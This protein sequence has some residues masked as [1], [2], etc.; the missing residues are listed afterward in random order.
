MA[1]ASHLAPLPALL[2]DGPF[3]DPFT[4]AQWDILLALMDTIIPSIQRGPT[5]VQ[6]AT[7][8]VVADAEY[9][10]SIRVVKKVVAGNPDDEA[11]DKYFNEKASD[12]PQ[13]QALLKRALGQDIPEESR[14]GL[15]FV[16]S[17]L[18]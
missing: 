8:L 13:F 15:A 2:P 16:L 4:P 18:K 11:L 7:H 6:K 10:N 14:K 5:K 9:D 1:L 17:T 3:K 12:S